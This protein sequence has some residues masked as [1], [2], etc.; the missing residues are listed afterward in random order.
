M[1]RRR[2]LVPSWQGCPLS[3]ICSSAPQRLSA[4]AGACALRCALGPPCRSCCL[5]LACRKDLRHGGKFSGACCARPRCFQAA[6]VPAASKHAWKLVFLLEAASILFCVH[7]HAESLLQLARALFVEPDLLLLDEPTNHLDLHAVLW[8]EV[9]S[10]LLLVTDQLAVSVLSK[11]LEDSAEGNFLSGLGAALWAGLPAEVPKDA[12][13]CIARAGVPQCG[14]HRCHPPAQ[15]P[16]SH[17]DSS[18]ILSLFVELQQKLHAFQ[19]YM[20]RRFYTEAGMQTPAHQTCAPGRLAQMVVLPRS[21]K[22]TAYRG[23]YD[24]FEKTAAERMRNQRKAAESVA[25]KKQHMQVCRLTACTCMCCAFILGHVRKQYA[26]MMQQG[27]PGHS[28]SHTRYIP[29]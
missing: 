21:R 25:L 13:H 19:A 5:Q 1:E 15:V 28:S 3:P 8:L 24:T 18:C 4:A 6:L 14:L 12:T 20:R 22:L 26:D 16:A 9:R 2:A 11:C 27:P 10:S 23:N 7:A 17:Y 29:F